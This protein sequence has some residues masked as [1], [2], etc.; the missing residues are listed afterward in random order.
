MTPRLWMLGLLAWLLLRPAL[1]V[2]ATPAHLPRVEAGH[3]DGHLA[4]GAPQVADQVAKVRLS[5]SL[6]SGRYSTRSVRL[7]S[8]AWPLLPDAGPLYTR[9]SSRAL[10]GS[11]PQ[12]AP[13][14]VRSRASS[15]RAPPF[16]L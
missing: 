14:A 11:T 12:A 7:T 16:S 15:P 10:T 1:P 9:P 3:V 6:V 8:G 13:L 4:Y 2:H 5:L